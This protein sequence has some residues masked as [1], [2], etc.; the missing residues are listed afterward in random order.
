[1]KMLKV[2]EGCMKM[3]MREEDGENKIN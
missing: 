3:K 1:M 2:N